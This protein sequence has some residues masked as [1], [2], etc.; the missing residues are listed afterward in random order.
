MTH[1]VVDTNVP[2]VANGDHQQASAACQLSCVRFLRKIR[3]SG[4]VHIDDKGVILAEYRRYLAFKGDPGVGDAF[5]KHLN[6]NFGNAHFVRVV[7]ITPTQDEWGFVEFPQDE[8][9]K[10]FDLSDRVFVAVALASG[11]DPRI[12]NA[13]DSDW[14]NHSAVLAENGV[15]VIQ[16]CL[17][18]GKQG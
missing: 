15:E 1:V 9:L 4:V 2:I 13:V 17:S 18:Q 14:E 10:T 5:Y 16:L 8:R 12:A 3:K 6:D 11:S 7:P